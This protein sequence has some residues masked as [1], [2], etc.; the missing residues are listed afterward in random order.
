[1]PRVK[2]AV[3]HVKRRKNL[4]AK[5][6]GMRWGR[7]NKIRLARPAELKAGSYAY[8]DRRNK[9]RA[10]RNLWAIKINAAVRPI[11]LSYSRFIHA[12]KLKNITL[13][14]KSLSYLAEFKPAVFQKVVDAV[15]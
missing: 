4:L 15:K 11:G 9:K 1:M 6:K 2:R 14:R 7:K 12:L 10:F 13:D 3:Q 5:T 8:R